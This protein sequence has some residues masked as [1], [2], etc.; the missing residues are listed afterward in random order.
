MGLAS[1]DVVDFRNMEDALMGLDD[2]LNFVS[3]RR[4]EMGAL[5][6]RVESMI[7]SL[8][9]NMENTTASRSRIQDADF[10]SE[11]VNLTRAQ[12]TQQA[13]ASMLAQA[14]T[15]PQLALALLG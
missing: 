3:A 10:A 2:A 15:A 12:I 14:N 6:S 9:I 8:Q 1:L 7:N 5:Q 13:S 11:S 4:S